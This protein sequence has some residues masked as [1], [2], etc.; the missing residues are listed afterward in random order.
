MVHIVQSIEEEQGR[1]LDYIA[2][3]P[4][5]W[6]ALPH[7]PGVHIGSEE[8]I[9]RLGEMRQLGWIA[10][11]GQSGGDGRLVTAQNVRITP[12]GATRLRELRR[13]AVRVP[14]DGA[15][16]SDSY[17]EKRAKRA[18]FMKRLY[19]RSDGNTLEMF[20]LEEFAEGLDF[21]ES[22][23]AA[24][25]DY[26]E[27][28]GLITYPTF[29]SISITHGGVVEVEA[30]MSDAT[31][32]TEHFAAF[33]ILHVKDSTNVTIQAG[34]SHSTQNVSIVTVEQNAALVALLV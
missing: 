9:M 21:A 2:S 33:N 6:P 16:M 5:P 23:A 15:Q 20:E 24:T 14:T 29:G 8:L 3:S 10:C 11:D 18:G 1:I 31:R 28:E 19:E 32:P 4:I 22:A 27:A 26:L 25:A 30:A 17:P 13:A 12:L 7:P 34:T